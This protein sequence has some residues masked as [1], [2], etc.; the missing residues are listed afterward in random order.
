MVSPNA[1]P[2]MKPSPYSCTNVKNKPTTLPLCFSSGKVWRRIIITVNQIKWKNP[3]NPK[4]IPESTIDFD[5]AR[6][7]NVIE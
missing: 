1:P 3:P 4:N 5:K 2:I 7:I 6:P